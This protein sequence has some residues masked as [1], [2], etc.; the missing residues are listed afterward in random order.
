MRRAPIILST[1][2]AGV[3]ALL[4][5]K[6]RA[7]ALPTPAAVS[8]PS[9]GTSSGSAAPSSSSSSSSSSSKTAGASSSATKTATGDAVGTPYGNAQVRVTISGGKITKIEALQLQGNDRKSVEI[10]S[11][12]EPL[13]RQSAL[14]KQSAS[15]DAVSGATFTSASYE[16]S[17]QSALDKAGFKAANGARGSSQIPQVQDHR[18]GPGGIPPQFN[19][20]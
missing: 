1:T 5:F 9:P 4:S 14:T 8:A 20:N 3:A 19:G 16:A 10:S 2:V 13:L 6:A 7:P 18:G 17:L 11:F 15:I 12:A